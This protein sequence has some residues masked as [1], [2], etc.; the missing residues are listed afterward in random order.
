MINWATTWPIW[1]FW[2]I[3]LIDPSYPSDLQQIWPVW[4]IW[5]LWL[6]WIIWPI[7][8][9]WLIWLLWLISQMLHDHDPS[10]MFT[11]H[12]LLQIGSPFGD[13]GTH[14]GPFGLCGSPFYLEGSHS[15]NGSRITERRL[16]L[17]TYHSNSVLSSELAGVS[18]VGRWCKLCLVFDNSEEWGLTVVFLVAL[19]PQKIV[20]AVY[21]HCRLKKLIWLT[22]FGL[23]V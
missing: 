5:L 7:L 9:F 14:L 15:S 19:K 6:V 18:H 17:F 8:T 1:I 20:N 4:F 23:W 2:N 10:D 21:A 11:Y 3:W 22:F 12:A 16:F 13:L